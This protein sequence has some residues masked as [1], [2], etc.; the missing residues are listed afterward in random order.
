MLPAWSCLVKTPCR[1][2]H[3][4]EPGRRNKSQ[5]SA[6]LW[7]WRPQVSGNRDPTPA[8]P[9]TA[10]G[11]GGGG[12]AA[13]VGSAQRA[14]KNATLRRPRY[15]KPRLLDRPLPRVTWLRDDG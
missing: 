2:H 1:P 12:N 4:H 8:A 15:S 9:G 3:R 10:M 6:V 14:V 7:M 5:A 13:G 11:L